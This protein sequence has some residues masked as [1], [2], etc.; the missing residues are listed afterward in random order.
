MGVFVFHTL[1]CVAITSGLSVRPKKLIGNAQKS[2]NQL[3]QI[4]ALKDFNL[5]LDGPDEFT[6]WFTQTLMKT[7]TNGLKHGVEVGDG[8]K[9]FTNMTN[10]GPVFIYVKNDKILE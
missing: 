1:P 9:R 10:G 3:D 5:T 2:I 4:N 7:Q 6:L 8:V